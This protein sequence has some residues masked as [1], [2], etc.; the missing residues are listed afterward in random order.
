MGLDALRVY[1][2]TNHSYAYQSIRDDL[3]KQMLA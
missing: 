2:L 1:A 3:R